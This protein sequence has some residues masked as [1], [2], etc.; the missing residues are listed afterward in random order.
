MR[1]GILRAA[2]LGLAVVIVASCGGAAVPG[3]AAP[4]ETRATAAARAATF[5]P[6]PTA[7]LAPTPTAAPTTTPGAAA[8]GVPMT[9]MDSEA[10]PIPAPAPN[11]DELP[12]AAEDAAGLVRQFATIDA[13]LHDTNISAVKLAYMGHLQQLAL[14]RLADYPEWKDT[15][16][17]GLTATARAQVAGSF[18]AGKQLRSMSGFIPTR[19]PDWKIVAPASIDQLMGYY[20][21]A[22]QTFG[23]PWPYLAA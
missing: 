9:G 7:T 15:V 21:E 18:E 1:Q 16:L 5:T 22:E 8:T 19:L 2:S 3:E 14:G 11:F 23:V 4:A 12:V 17:A 6:E 10:T 20:K 13:A